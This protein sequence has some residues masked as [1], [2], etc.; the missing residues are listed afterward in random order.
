MDRSAATT[1]ESNINLEDMQ[2]LFS[3]RK[4]IVPRMF[5]KLVPKEDRE[6][7]EQE[8]ERLNNETGIAFLRLCRELAVIVGWEKLVYG[9]NK[10]MLK[11]GYIHSANMGFLTIQE[12]QNRGLVKI[13]STEQGDFY[14]Y[15]TEEL[16][17]DKGTIRVPK[18]AVDYDL[19]QDG[20]K[21][22]WGKGSGIRS[23]NQ[24]DESMDLALGILGGHE[25]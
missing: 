13:K 12:I 19:K 8:I 15:S 18:K 6:L 9:I 23:R 2:A 14:A 25:V 11:R 17:T 10:L 7:T 4:H 5:T 22:D 1:N 21:M 3:K 16:A 20:K 24:T